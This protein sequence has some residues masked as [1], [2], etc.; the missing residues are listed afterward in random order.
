MASAPDLSV[1]A[2]D[3]NPNGLKVGQIL[4]EQLQSHVTDK[5]AHPHAQLWGGCGEFGSLGGPTPCVCVIRVC[6]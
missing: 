2:R 3:C 5:P 1:S 6:E 4:V